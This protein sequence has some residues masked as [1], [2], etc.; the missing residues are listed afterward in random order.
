VK[1]HASIPEQLSAD[2][3]LPELFGSCYERLKSY[4]ALYSCD[5]GMVRDS[6]QDLYLYLAQRPQL[7]SQIDDFESYMKI[8]LRRGLS[9]KRQSA[10]KTISTESVLLDISVPSFEERLIDIQT[11]EEKAA[12]VQVLLSHLTPTQK[13]VLA[14]RFFKGLSYDDIAEKMGTTKRTVY[15][16]IHSCMKK[17]R[18]AKINW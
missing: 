15:N 8:S 7:V 11:N 6:L 14:L 10:R 2:S 12:K 16:Q 9:A 3:R 18:S 17:L 4:G 13:S 1:P 5:E